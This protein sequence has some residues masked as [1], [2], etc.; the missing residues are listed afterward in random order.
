MVH[1]KCLKK[2]NFTVVNDSQFC[3][4]C[5]ASVPIRYN[6]FKDITLTQSHIENDD[7]D[8]H[9]YNNEFFETVDNLSNAST[10]LEQCRSYSADEI[11]SLIKPETDFSAFFYNIDGNKTNFDCLAAELHTLKHKFS[12][13]GLA[14][15]NIE[16]QQACLYP[17]DNYCSFYN[18]VADGKSKGTGIALYVHESL[19]ATPIEMTCNT[20]PNIESMFLKVAKGKSSVNVGIIYRPPNGNVNEFLDDFQDIINKLPRKPTFILG[21]F[22]IDLNKENDPI[23]NHF[24]E[25]F[26]S[27][28]LLPSISLTTHKRNLSKG[29]CIDN[30]FTNSIDT[31]SHSGTIHDRGTDRSPIFITSQL[32]LDGKSCKINAPKQKLYYNFSNENIDSLI[33][34]LETKP[35]HLFGIACDEPNFTKHFTTFTEAIDKSCKLQTPRMTKRTT[36]NNPWIT[37]GIIQAVKN[38]TYLYRKWKKSCSSRNPSGDTKLYSDYSS[39]RR[40]LKNVIKQAKAK[41]YHTKINLCQKQT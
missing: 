11:S 35:P 31:V 22:N 41:F 13:I 28:G 6:P 32:N 4:L 40:C 12:I 39:Y 9:F 7:N 29:S 33:D 8:D 24:E 20:T 14:E 18:E 2:S 1:T 3:G 23:K 17:L 19:K 27:H 30:I 15:T 34:D 36:T 5:H 25:I 21:D 10:V 38:K 26:L 16:P 37:P